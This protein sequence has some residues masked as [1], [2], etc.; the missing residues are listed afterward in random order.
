M[1]NQA[2]IT[3]VREYNHIHVHSLC[4]EG[5]RLRF[6][7]MILY[8]PVCNKGDNPSLSNDMKLV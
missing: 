5:L 1:P 8:R 3:N 6:F 7:L 2:N 4:L